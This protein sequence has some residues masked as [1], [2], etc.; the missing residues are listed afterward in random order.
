ME[1]LTNLNKGVTK[2][3][4]R[5]LQTSAANCMLLE[6][7]HLMCS[8]ALVEKGNLTIGYQ[9]TKTACH[10]L[11]T[12]IHEVIRSAGPMAINHQVEVVHLAWAQDGPGSISKL[13]EEMVQTSHVT[14]VTS[15]C[16]TDAFPS[17][18]I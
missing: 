18:H 9:V 12:V 17:V 11:D 7:Q 2:K 15:Y 6:K 8:W 1:F 10:T 16:F 5:V 14:Y 3:T 13:H 4:S